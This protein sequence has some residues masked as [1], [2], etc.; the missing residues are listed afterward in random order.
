[1]VCEGVG[2]YAFEYMTG[3]TGV[4]LGTCGPC[5]G[6]GMT[7]GSL[8]LLDR[9]GEAAKQLH[10]DV[11][12]VFMDGARLAALRRLIEDFASAT[13][14]P[15]VASILDGWDEVAPNFIAVEPVGPRPSPV[16][17][18]PPQP[19]DAAQLG[20]NREP[21]APETSGAAF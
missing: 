8:F 18:G 7:G 6:S 1:M 19:V 14:S 15:R 2:K 20:A 10:S 4:V 12:A 21:R 13:S 17:A 9:D 3:G 11:E 16:A 5:I